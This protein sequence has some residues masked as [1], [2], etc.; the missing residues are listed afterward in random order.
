MCATREG[1]PAR[2]SNP[3]GRDEV[4]W[5]PV[6]DERCGDDGFAGPAI[7]ALHRVGDLVP[8]PETIVLTA[9]VRHWR[10]RVRQRPAD[11]FAE[12]AG[13]VEEPVSVRAW[14][15]RP[16]RSDLPIGPVFNNLG[17]G[18][19]AE[20]MLELLALAEDGAREFP[21]LAFALQRFTAA[22]ASAH[23]HAAPDGERVRVQAFL[24]LAE[25]LSE[26][27]HPDLIV[28]A[29]P[30]LAVREYRVADKPTATVAAAG[31]SRTSTVAE[32][33]RRAP[34]LRVKTVQHLGSLAIAAARRLAVP[35]AA[36]FAVT[37]GEVALL[38]CRPVPP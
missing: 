1:G 18:T 25:Q 4:R 10:D 29:G 6:T 22:E 37:D 26:P 17:P 8:V 9:P 32:L 21:R 36:E 16:R 35:V 12:Y 11:P 5:L 23:V 2:P 28:L 31:G 13:L 34:A 38:R 19:V 3:A 14:Q 20:A 24:G 27:L 7:G 33:R 15:I 30:E